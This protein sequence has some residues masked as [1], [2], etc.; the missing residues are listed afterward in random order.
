MFTFDE[1]LF[2]DLHKDAFGFRPR[3]HEF[4]D[5]SA[6][7]KQVIWDAT[8]DALDAELVRECRCALDSQRKWE[9]KIAKFIELGAPDEA[10]AIRWD[11]DANGIE[12]D[13][14]QRNGYYCFI[15][16]IAY[17]HESRVASAFS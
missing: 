14:P 1:Y 9:A 11:M 10:T 16:G 6:D 7:R 3:G 5:A 8:C 15:M 13:D 2:S 12:A 17:M 4:Y